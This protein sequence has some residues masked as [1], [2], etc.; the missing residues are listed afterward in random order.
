MQ[1]SMIDV[2]PNKSDRCILSNVG[3]YRKQL[4]ASG[5]HPQ[6]LSSELDKFRKYASLIWIAVLVELLSQLLSIS[7]SDAGESC[8]LPIKSQCAWITYF[9][10]PFLIFFAQIQAHFQRHPLP[11]LKAPEIV[12]WSPATTRRSDWAPGNASISEKFSHCFYDSRH[13]LDE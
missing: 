1:P 3:H 6:Y 8:R 13:I 2:L 12:S 9:K 4:A 7:L 5:Q 11:R 10:L